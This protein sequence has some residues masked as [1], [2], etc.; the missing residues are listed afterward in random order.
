[1][2]SKPEIETAQVLVENDPMV[3]SAGKANRAV[4]STGWVLTVLVDMFLLIDGGA[5][6]AGFKPYVDGL[7][8]FGYPTSLA[9]PIGLS[10]LISTILM[11]VPRTAVLGTILVTGY[12]GGAT[13]TQVR[14]QDAWFLVPGVLGAMA[15]LVLYPGEGRVRGLIPF[16]RR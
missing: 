11:L 14:V 2:T 5:R 15:G 9:T 16:R 10:L 7:T 3:S 6:V 4:S 1:M 13:A 8:Q 12:L